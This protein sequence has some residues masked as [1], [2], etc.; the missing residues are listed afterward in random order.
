MNEQVLKQRHGSVAPGAGEISVGVSDALTARIAER[1]GYKS[2]FVTGAGVTNT[3]LGLPDMAFLSFKELL[4]QVYAIRDAV[5]VSIAV[6]ADTGFGNA[7]NVGR[8]VRLLERAGADSITIEDQVSPKRCG[9]FQGKA[10]ISAAEMVQKIKA[11][12]DARKSPKTLIQ[13]RTDARA[14]EGLDAALDR[15]RAY[16]E[17][18]ADL[19]FVEAPLSLEELARIPAEVPG[20]HTCNMVIGGLTPILERAELAR[21]GF[22]R[23]GYANAGLQTAAAA[24]EAVFRH[25]MDHGSIRGFEGRVLSFAERQGLL[26]KDHFDELESRYSS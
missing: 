21:L 9:H 14:T 20:V 18:G 26:N 15:A 16:Q 3:H 19:L 8:T 13:A 1:V 22:A 12:V 25:L 7:I 11:A 23:I 17:A 24:V 6:D 4:D 5:S 2:V 10:V